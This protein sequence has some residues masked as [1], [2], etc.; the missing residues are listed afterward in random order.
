MR[1]DLALPLTLL[2]HRS[3]TFR[4]VSGLSPPRTILRLVALYRV[5]LHLASSYLAGHSSALPRLTSPRLASSRLVSPHLIS[6][7]VSLCLVSSPLGLPY[8]ASSRLTSSRLATT[9]LDSTRLHSVLSSPLPML[10]FFSTELLRR[11]HRA[12]F[13]AFVPN[14]GN[15]PII[16]SLY[17]SFLFVCYVSLHYAITPIVSVLWSMCL[18]V[19]T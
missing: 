19:V 7:L 14:H 8:L 3:A 5:S 11:S 12:V 16:R 18:R 4:L 13:T 1:A 17:A 9:R 15:L 6:R 10:V 2:V